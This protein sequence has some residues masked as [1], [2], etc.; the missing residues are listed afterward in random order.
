[1]KAQQTNVDTIANNISNVN[2]VGYKSQSAQFKSLLYQTL[3]TESTTANGDPKPT[4]AQVGLGTRIASTNTSF[5]QGAMTATDSATALCISGDGFF[6]VRDL[7]G[8]V[9]YTR[10]GDFTWSLANDGAR[11]LTTAEGYYVLDDNGN[12]ITLPEGASGDTVSFGTEGQ[13]AYRGADGN[14]IQ[15]GQSVGVFQFNNP[16]G[17]EKTGE[18]MWAATESSGAPLNEANA[19]G[20]TRSKIN[21]GYLE[22]SNVNVADEMVN[23]IVAQRAYELNSRAI[24]TSDTMLEQANNLRR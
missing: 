13:L 2:T 22:A 3:Q 18:S 15:T 1:M 6:S 19:A 21:Q 24:T 23:L 4:T 17:L 7:D 5:A 8:T 9:K 11:V 20:I 10:N 14:Y 12:R 16:K